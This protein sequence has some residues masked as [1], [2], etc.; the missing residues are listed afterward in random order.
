MITMFQHRGFKYSALLGQ[1]ET[2]RFQKTDLPKSKSHQ[3]CHF[4]VLIHDKSSWLL[5]WASSLLVP[6]FPF[7]PHPHWK[8]NDVLDE[9]GLR[10][11]GVSRIFLVVGVTEP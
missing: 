5:A 3:G 10:A 11:G 6:V 9:C 7:V 1:S 2:F 8:L 4:R